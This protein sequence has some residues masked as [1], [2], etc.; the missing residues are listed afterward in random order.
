MY[1]SISTDD[2]DGTIGPSVFKL[3]RGDVEVYEFVYWRLLANNY[4]G[5]RQRGQPRFPV[6]I[7]PFRFVIKE[8]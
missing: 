4:L 1:L 2:G 8:D 3:A 7:A 5:L 6:G